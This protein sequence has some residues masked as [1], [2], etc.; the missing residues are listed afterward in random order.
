MKFA[1]TSDGFNINYFDITTELSAVLPGLPTTGYA[2]HPCY[3][4]PFNP[5]TT[6]SYDLPEPAKVSLVIYDVAGKMVLTLVAVE[7][8][9]AGR[10]E[11]VWNGRDDKGQ[12]VAAGVYF[13]R[14]DAGE[15][16]ETRRMTLV[17]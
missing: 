14:L 11:E 3:P 7:D 12:I 8:V 6:I 4:N 5:M 2:L 16:S 13:Y 17:K 1:P 15:Y 9:G 10:H